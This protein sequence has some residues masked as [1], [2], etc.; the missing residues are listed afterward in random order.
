VTTRSNPAPARAD[1]ALSRAARTDPALARA[2][3]FLSDNLDQ[4]HLHRHF[5]RSLG[6]TP[7]EYAARLRK[8]VQ[9]GRRE[10]E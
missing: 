7:G 1:P 4:S 5:R 2:C 9:D 6:T 8:N 10:R 3:E